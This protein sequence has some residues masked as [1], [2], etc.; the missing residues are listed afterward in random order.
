MRAAP[1]GRRR[2]NGSTPRARRGGG[3]SSNERVFGF[4]FLSGAFHIDHHKRRLGTDVSSFPGCCDL[5]NEHSNV[6]RDFRRAYAA[7]LEMC[8]KNDV[9]DVFAQYDATPVEAPRGSLTGS[10]QSTF[11]HC[12]RA[13]RLSRNGDVYEVGKFCSVTDG[14]GGRVVGVFRIDGFYTSVEGEFFYVPL[15]FT[16]ILLTI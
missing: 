1:A 15:H 11:A 12:Y 5:F 6:T 8:E 3:K 14:K 4:A 16:R 7:W 2:D 9:V 10:E 13:K